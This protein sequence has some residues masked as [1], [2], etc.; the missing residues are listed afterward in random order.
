MLRSKC[1]KAQ[2][3]EI[4]YLCQLG[5]EYFCHLAGAFDCRYMQILSDG[6]SR[7]CGG[8]SGVCRSRLSYSGIHKHLLQSRAGASELDTIT[9]RHQSH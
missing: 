1:R 8:L 4:T 9:E 2:L 5:R 6:V 3:M 7:E